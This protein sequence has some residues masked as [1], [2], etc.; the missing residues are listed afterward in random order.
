MRA[1]RLALLALLLLALLAGELHAA[2]NPYE[3]LG[4]KRTASAKEIK[5][6]FHKFALQYHPDKVQSAGRGA[7]G[8]R[9]R[10]A[11]RVVAGA[12]APR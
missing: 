7:G 2:K 1:S 9:A 10:R 5:K 12:P 11:W 4:V 6:A 3:L 8:A